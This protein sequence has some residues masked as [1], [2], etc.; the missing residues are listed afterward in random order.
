MQRCV[1]ICP[2]L[3]APGNGG[4]PGKTGINALSIVRHGVGLRPLRANGPRIEKEHREDEGITVVHAYGHG[5]A[6]YQSSYG[7]AMAVCKL[8]EDALEDRKRK[9][10]M[11]SAFGELKLKA[12][13]D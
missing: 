4:V 8:L 2:Q 13:R 5:G 7:S 12:S 6:G 11:R 10:D 3:T 9:T 1:D